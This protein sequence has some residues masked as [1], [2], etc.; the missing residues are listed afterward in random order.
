MCHCSKIQKESKGVL[1]ACSSDLIWFPTSFGNPCHKWEL[2]ECWVWSHH[3]AN[4][5]VLLQDTRNLLTAGTLFWT[6]VRL[7]RENG[8]KSL[9]K[10]VV[11]GRLS[12]CKKLQCNQFGFC[13]P[14]CKDLL[15]LVAIL[16]T[17]LCSKPQNRSFIWS[18]CCLVTQY[19]FMS[20]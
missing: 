5:L 9:Q 15:H 16:I 11:L 17:P 1:G 6:Q 14:V 7:E 13:N 8:C 18:V 19:K 12:F 10:P 4:K 3:S 2:R 20:N